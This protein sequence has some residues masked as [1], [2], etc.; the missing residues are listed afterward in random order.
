MKGFKATSTT[1]A[2]TIDVVIATARSSRG[3][4]GLQST[5]LVLFHGSPLVLAKS[6]VFLYSV[7][8]LG[9]YRKA[10]PQTPLAMLINFR[11]R[12]FLF[13]KSTKLSGVRPPYFQA[14]C[15]E[16]PRQSRKSRNQGPRKKGGGDTEWRLDSCT[17]K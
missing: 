2:T 15:L 17:Q 6:P 8:M 5:V 1:I 10:R 3:F 14:L 12:S 4:F 13:L 7:P 9:M 16:I 11:K